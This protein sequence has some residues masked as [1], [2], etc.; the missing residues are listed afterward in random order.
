MYRIASYDNKHKNQVIELILDIQ[1]NEFHI[2]ISINEQQDL[3]TI[4]EHYKQ[5]NGNFWVA[6]NGND[7]IGTIALM[8]IGQSRG[9]LRKMFVAKDHRGKEKRIAQD[10]YDTVEA[11]C[12]SNEIYELYL[13]T[14]SVLK[15]AHRFYMRNG[16]SLI[17][18][19][20][21]PETFPV[22]AVDELFFR[23]RIE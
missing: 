14:V 15:A 23:K 6:L 12:K 11:H 13:G 9:A 18:K 1:Q 17:A 4:D 8:D 5:G 22:L 10:L 3:L 21:L 19:E 20:L 7:V 16:F 2:P